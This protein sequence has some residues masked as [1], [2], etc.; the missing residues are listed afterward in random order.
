MTR[1]TGNP[2]VQLIRRLVEGQHLK[3][4]PDQELLRRFGSGQD[5]AAFHSLLRRHGP[6]VLEVC[7]NVLGNESDA[8]DAFQATFLIFAQKA[9]AI[10]KGS[11]VGSWLYGV[12]Y[13]TALKAQ[14]E[15]AKR[16]KHEACVTGRTPEEVSSD[17]SWRE[18]RQVLHAELHRLSESYRAPLVLCY[19]EGKTQ[20]ETA[21]LLG[22]SKATVKQRL[23]RG[24]SLLRARLVRRGLGPAAVLAASVWPT[25]TVPACL[26]PT[27]VGSTAKAAIAVA[28]GRSAIEGLVSAKA[29]ALALRGL[30]AML[31]TKLQNATAGVLLLGLL[32]STLS[33]AVHAGLA[34]G[35]P[36]GQ[37][38]RQSP[39]ANRPA[40]SEEDQLARVL[41]AVDAL[42]AQAKAEVLVRLAR[43]Q[44]QAGNKDAARTSLQQASRAAQTI[45]DQGARDW[46]VI[47]VAWNQ[48]ELND[49]EAVKR[50][51]AS[52]QE[53]SLRVHG[54]VFVGKVQ[55]K[56]GNRAAAQE[57]FREATQLAHTLSNEVR[58]GFVSSPRVLALETVGEGQVE[59]GDEVGALATAEALRTISGK[60]WAPWDVWGKIAVARAERG[61]VKG[62]LRMV[63]QIEADHGKKSQSGELQAALKPGQTYN[64]EQTKAAHLRGIAVARAKAGYLDE[65]MRVAETIPDVDF[66]VSRAWTLVFIARQKAA[67]G[68]VRQALQIVAKLP[69]MEKPFVL[70]AVAAA[71]AKAGDRKAAQATLAEAFKLAKDHDDD[72]G[73]EALFLIAEVQAQMGQVEEA[74]K[75]AEAVKGRNGASQRVELYDAPFQI[76]TYKHT[77]LLFISR[78]QS[79]AGD[80]NGAIKTAEAT[81]T[82]DER[83]AAYADTVRAYCYY[84]IARAMARMGEGERALAWAKEHNSALERSWALQGLAEEILA[85]RAKKAPGAK[86]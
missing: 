21:T 22:V 78:A 42:P 17:L 73:P 83:E 5:E 79:K 14:A 85:R 6:M 74:F 3:E 40:P 31:F 45:Q 29:A 23:E 25:A 20:D 32:A 24:R 44:A 11:S 51:V 19:L 57:T 82:G 71:Q 72:Y 16:H 77:A 28:A 70:A 8:E 39:P 76:Q 18:I 66:D 65:A 12:A 68:E 34:P 35:L 67:A 53:D 50:T 13:R 54:L 58:P 1:T 52:L 10:R 4:L 2:I 49:L 26:P 69:E 30:K 27:L 9:G 55:V 86:E 60:P 62:A 59:A 41:Q 36:G 84:E 75:T 56:G 37:P 33:V 43:A 80:I 38:P 81:R 47:L 48:E 61:D 46:T 64:I 7:R 63:E 15:F